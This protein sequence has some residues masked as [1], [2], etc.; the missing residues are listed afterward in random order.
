MA[1]ALHPNAKH[2]CVYVQSAITSWVRINL[3]AATQR[4]VGHVQNA[5]VQVLWFCRDFR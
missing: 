3:D 1:G 5:T 2:C 4:L